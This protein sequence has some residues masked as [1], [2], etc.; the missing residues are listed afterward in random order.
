[1]VFSFVIFVFTADAGLSIGA[2]FIL[3]C[4]FFFGAVGAYF[5]AFT[6]DGGV[7]KSKAV[8][9]SHRGWDVRSYVYYFI[10]YP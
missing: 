1:V 10:P 5:R 3:F 4:V 6:I 9:T 7:S 8:E 2:W